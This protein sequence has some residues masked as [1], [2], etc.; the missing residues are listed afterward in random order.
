MS[1]DDVVTALAARLTTGMAG[2]AIG[3][4][5]Y[6]YAPDTLNPPT[7]IVLPSPSDFLVWDRTFDGSDDYSV[8]V[9]IIMGSQDDRSGQAE[10]LSY[11]DRTGSTSLYAVI[12]ADRTLGGTVSMTSIIRGTAYGDV[13]WGGVTFFGGELTV[14]CGT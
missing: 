7:A 2:T 12:N 4:R 14:E 1:I 11:F 3:G 6:A 13:E 10:L 9:K 8:T 5:I